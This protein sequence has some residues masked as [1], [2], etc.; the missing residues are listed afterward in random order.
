MSTHHQF[1]ASDQCAEVE[2]IFIRST[3]LPHIQNESHPIIP[4]CNENEWPPFNGWPI[5]VLGVHQFF[6]HHRQT[7]ITI[8]YYSNLFSILLNLEQQVQV[9]VFE[10]TPPPLDGIS[11]SA[12]CI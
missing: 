6:L 10:V 11:H 7:C 12:Y 3:P 1:P 2:H 9:R 4:V 8:N 5:Y